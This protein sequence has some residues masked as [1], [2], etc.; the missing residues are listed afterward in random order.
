MQQRIL[1]VLLSK[2]VIKI[3]LEYALDPE[4]QGM[5]ELICERNSDC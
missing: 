3:A 5:E 4:D 1:V 2:P